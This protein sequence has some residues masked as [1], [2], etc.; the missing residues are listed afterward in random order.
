MTH[1]TNPTTKSFESRL[2]ESDLP[3]PGPSHYAARRALWLAAPVTPPQSPPNSPSNSRQ[4]LE[5]LLSSPGAVNND[6]IWKSGVEKVWRGLNAGQRLK[7]T[8]PLNLVIKILHFA[9]IR[10]STWPVGLEAG[11]DSEHE[12]T[13]DPTS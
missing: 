6:E 12:R 3:P 5:L 10:D 7:R 11:P 9:W 1:A 13:L 8:L 2:A 4:R